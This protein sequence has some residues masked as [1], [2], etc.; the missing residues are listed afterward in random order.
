MN[1]TLA[2]FAGL[3]VASGLVVA[4]LGCAAPPT[5]QLAS[6]HPAQAD[7]GTVRRLCVLPFVGPKGSGELAFDTVVNT[8]RETGYYELADAN[9]LQQFVVAPLYRDD[10]LVNTPVAIDAAERMRL[11]AILV[12]RV[13]Y[14]QEST[15]IQIG[16]PTIRAVVQYEL[17]DVRSRRVLAQGD[18]AETFTGELSDGKTDPSSEQRVFARLAR[19]SA[20]E[21]ARR[22]APHRQAIEAE[23]AAITFGAG[24]D[25]LR[26]GNELAEQGDWEHAVVQWRMAL[27]EDPE[28]HEAMY[29]IGLASEA[30][31]DFAAAEHQYAAAARIENRVEYRTSLNRV[32][33]AAPRQQVALAQWHRVGLPVAGQ[34]PPGDRPASMPVAQPAGWMPPREPSA[35]PTQ[36][37]RYIPGAGSGPSGNA[38]NARWY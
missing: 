34:A 31:G 12:G 24:A 8:L 33:E 4:F 35:P 5:V 25:L 28:C 3:S 15:S 1:S 17:I 7:V 14:Q 2:R 37:P 26:A 23:L 38:P 18:A 27:A 20:E 29:N 13:R 21:V 19:S 36:D 11:D 9:A 16:V 6:W 30:R 32:A 10:G 22:I